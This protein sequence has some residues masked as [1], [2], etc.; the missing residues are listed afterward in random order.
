MAA[1]SETVFGGLPIFAYSGNAAQAT[2]TVTLKGVNVRQG[3][4]K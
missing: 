1:D 3:A 2:G 4:A